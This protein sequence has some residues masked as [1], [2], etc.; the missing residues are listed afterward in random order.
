MSTIKEDQEHRPPEQ[1]CSSAEKLKELNAIC[2]KCMA[3][4]A[5]RFET[6]S[7]KDCMYCPTGAQIH[8]LD[9]KSWDKVD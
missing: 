6:I 8:S 2:Q 3:Q 7:A 5:K 1:S 4:A 9:D